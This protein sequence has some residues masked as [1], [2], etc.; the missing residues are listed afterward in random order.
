MKSDVDATSHLIVRRT[1]GA[2]ALDADHPP[3]FTNGNKKLVYSLACPEGTRPGGELYYSRWR[4]MQL[5]ELAPTRT[6]LLEMREDVF[7]YEAPQAGVVEWH[8]NFADPFLFV[9]YGGPLLAQDELQVRPH[10][11]SSASPSWRPS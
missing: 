8:M 5:P 2:A 1:F 11:W 9:A 10:C 3:R 7:G 4:A 6:P